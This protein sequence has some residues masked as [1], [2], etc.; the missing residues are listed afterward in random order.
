MSTAAGCSKSQREEN[1]EGEAIAREVVDEPWV[2]TPV[3]QP[4]SGRMRRA[5]QTSTA[6]R[7]GTRTV[8]AEPSMSEP[9]AN[10]LVNRSRAKETTV[11]RP[12]SL[13][14]IIRL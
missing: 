1:W 6:S 3:L 13:V 12:T 8:R 14:A 11:E 5:C 9:V 2:T 4:P 7:P 10:L